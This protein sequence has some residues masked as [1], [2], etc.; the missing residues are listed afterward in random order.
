[1]TDASDAFKTRPYI[2]KET[3]DIVE[4][5][6]SDVADEQKLSDLKITQ[7]DYNAGVLDI[8]LSIDASEDP[9]QK[10]PAA[11][12]AILE[13]ETKFY[14]VEYKGYTVAKE[15]DPKTEQVTGKINYIYKIDIKGDGIN[16]DTA[17]TTENTTGEE[18]TGK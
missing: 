7:F 18:G 16:L 8:T 12:T 14:Y 11:V 2:L 6:A 1:M 10:Y 4:K 9:A 5:A 13:K 15:I 3:Y 17:E